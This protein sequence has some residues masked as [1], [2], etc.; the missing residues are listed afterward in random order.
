MP[1]G[2][3]KL[4]L[5]RDGEAFDDAAGDAAAGVSGRL[6]GEVVRLVVYDDGAADNLVH[7]EAVGEKDRQ[8]VTV[9]AEQRG[10]VA[11]V[12]GMGA[13]GRV[14]VAAGGGKRVG[15]A[16]AAGASLV[17]VESEEA[18][19]AGALRGRQAGDVHGDDDAVGR[20]VKEGDAVD[21]GVQDVAAEVRPRLRRPVQQRGQRM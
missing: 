16:A 3:L 10:Q 2:R 8:R 20:L 21:A 18:A 1:R 9:A 4:R 11:G 13:A 7:T 12:E 14:E 17:D 19:A 15:G 6:G 5:L